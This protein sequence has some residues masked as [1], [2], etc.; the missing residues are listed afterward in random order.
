MTST[1]LTAPSRAQSDATWLRLAQLS[2]AASLVPLVVFAVV[3]TFFTTI[4]EGDF[5]YT[6]DYWY[7]AMGLPF[8]LVGIGLALGVHRLQHG[9]DGRLGTIGV[10]VNTIALTELFVQLLVSVAIGAEVRWGPSYPIFTVLSFV[11]V[12]LLAAGSWRTGL[13]PRW[14]LG[15]WPALWI[16]GT[17]AAS[18]PMPLLLAGFLVAFGVTLTRRVAGRAG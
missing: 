16:L 8:A 6:A 14:L 11:G 9:A 7:T 4:S 18:G 3:G 13:L 12:A 17:F 10:W 5:R 2:V 1:S 15:L